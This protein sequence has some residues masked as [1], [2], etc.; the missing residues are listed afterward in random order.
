MV[1]D[2]T[3]TP[4]RQWFKAFTSQPHQPFFILGLAIF[5]YSMLLLTLILS[6]VIGINISLF[7]VYNLAQLMPTC[8]FLG[9]LLTVLYRFLFV[10]PFLYKE[11]MAIFW[12]LAFGF[13]L[14]QIAFL[15]FPILLAIGQL[16][17]VTAQLLA[18]RIFINAYKIS[19][20]SDKHDPFWIIFMFSMGALSNILFIL[21][22]FVPQIFILAK[23][24]SFIA[25]CVGIVFTISQKMLVSFL[26]FYLERSPIIASKKLVATVILSLILIALSSSFHFDA[27]TLVGNALGVAATGTLF[28]KQDVLFRKAP[29]ILSI[30]Q[31]GIF[32]LLLAFFAGAISFFIPLPALFQTHTFALGFVGTMII[33]FGSRVALGHSGRRIES[34]TYTTG[35]FLAFQIAII[36]RLLASFEPFFLVYSS[37]FL[38]FVLI[39]WIYRYA[40]MLLKL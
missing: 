20:A 18:L 7:H 6:G 36:L 32:W 40:P 34:D 1:L 15:L 8:F 23:N 22:N 24:L 13:I 3:E 4:F 27:L 21:S 38:C 31:A 30:L 39:A 29:P 10:V 37:S 17:I 12:L 28:Y 16:F 5:L 14:V 35:I 26:G 33:G 2:F 9:F 19:H 25:F 11:Y